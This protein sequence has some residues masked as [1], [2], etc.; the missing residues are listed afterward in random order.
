MYPGEVIEWI[1]APQTGTDIKEMAI[2]LRDLAERAGGV[3]D[4]LRGNID[5][6]IPAWGMAQLLAT[7]A[8]RVFNPISDNIGITVAEMLKHTAYCLEHRHGETVYVMVDQGSQDRRGVKRGW[9]GLGPDDLR[10]YYAVSVEI[11]TLTEDKRIQQGQ[12]GLQMQQAGAISMEEFREQYLM[13]P[14]P[15]DT[16]LKVMV[17]KVRNSDPYLQVF[18]DRV[19][20][21]LA[22]K[23][24]Q[25]TGAAM[26]LP[27][28][29]GGVPQ[30]GQLPSGQMPIPGTPGEAMPAEQ[31][32]AQGPGVTPILGAPAPMAPTPGLGIA[33][34]QPMIQ[35][36]V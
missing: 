23:D 15:E 19:L 13:I 30:A 31:Q 16:E 14:N 9:L 4:I 3:P 5:R 6:N 22:L 36:V 17:E 28:Q 29:A 18:M 11:N 21:R 1:G 33:V 25:A 24:V 20:K 32:M 7:A 35:P 2:L 34:T 8:R 12:F 26:G 27:V 10:G